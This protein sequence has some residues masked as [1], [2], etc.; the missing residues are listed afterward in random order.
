MPL[1]AGKPAAMRVY[2]DEVDQPTTY[3]VDSNLDSFAPQEV[4]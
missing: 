2:F 4:G 1:V 3:F